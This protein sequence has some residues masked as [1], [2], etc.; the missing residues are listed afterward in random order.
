M[1]DDLCVGV[2]VG[3]ID[4]KGASTK[5]G[6]YERLVV[7][8]PDAEVT[9]FVA[10]IVV[11]VQVVFHGADVRGVRDDRVGVGGAAVAADGD[12]DADRGGD[13]TGVAS[14]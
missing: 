2:R 8:A 14:Q 12:R 9:G 3:H 1:V 10:G 7:D 11:L 4:M 5:T 6:P 13:V